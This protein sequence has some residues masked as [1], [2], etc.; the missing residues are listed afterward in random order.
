MN[1]PESYI[2]EVLAALIQTSRTQWKLIFLVELSEVLELRAA[3]RE[4]LQYD[5]WQRYDPPLISFDWPS[6]GPAGFSGVARTWNPG[7]RRQ[8][9]NEVTPSQK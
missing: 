5:L 8:R 6:R 9:Y 1:S 3:T 4:R 7:V 2:S